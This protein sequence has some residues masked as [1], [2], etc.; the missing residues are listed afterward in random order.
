LNRIGVR[1]LGARL[2]VGAV[3]GSLEQAKLLD[4]PRDGRLRRLEAA[5]MKT[6]T[7]LLLAVERFVFDEL[8]KCGLATRFH[9]R[10]FLVY[11]ILHHELS[12]RDF[13]FIDFP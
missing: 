3:A 6:A 9:V 10:G 7:E 1:R 4:I 8:E 13:V 2:L 12:P 11:M 5:S